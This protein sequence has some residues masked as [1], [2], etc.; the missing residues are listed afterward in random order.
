[1]D[2][3]VN[4]DPDELQIWGLTGT[5]DYALTGNLKFRAEV[6]YDSLE[7]DLDTLFFDSGSSIRGIPRSGQQLT[8]DDNVTA[9]FEVIYTF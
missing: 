1:V 9:G 4:S 5:M 2:L 8:E 3:E 7:G 6:R